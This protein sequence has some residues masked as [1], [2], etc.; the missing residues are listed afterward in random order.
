MEIIKRRLCGYCSQRNVREDCCDLGYLQAISTPCVPEAPWAII[1]GK[2][3]TYEEYQAWQ[4]D[5]KLHA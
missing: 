5:K 2:I 3:F 4:K 1:E